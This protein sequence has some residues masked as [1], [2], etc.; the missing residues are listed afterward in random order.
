MLRAYREASVVRRASRMISSAAALSMA[1]TTNE[2]ADVVELSASDAEAVE[3]PSKH[4]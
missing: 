4:V 2:A 3:P 1:Y